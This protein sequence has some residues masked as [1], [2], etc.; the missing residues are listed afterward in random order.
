VSQFTSSLLKLT[1]QNAENDDHN[2]PRIASR[3]LF[4]LSFGEDNLLHRRS[5]GKHT[6]SASLTIVNLSNKYALYNFLSTFSGT[7]YV[8]PRSITG[9]LAYHF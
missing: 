3:N 1:A 2:P 7:H 4:D 8:S 6:L 5:A 9:E